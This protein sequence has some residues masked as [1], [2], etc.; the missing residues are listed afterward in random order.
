M[1]QRCGGSVSVKG[2]IHGRAYLHSNKPKA[3]LAEKVM[4][5]IQWRMPDETRTIPHFVM[6]SP[7]W[8]AAEEGCGFYGGH[9]DSAAAGGAADIRGRGQGQQ[10]RQTTD[11]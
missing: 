4:L 5:F 9:E 11:R 7:L 1:V 8:T 3:R 10:P 2:A 6:K